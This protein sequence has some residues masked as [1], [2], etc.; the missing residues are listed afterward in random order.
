MKKIVCKNSQGSQ[1]TFCYS[2]PFWLEEYTGIHELSGKISTVKSAFGTGAIYID[3]SINERNITISGKIRKEDI[4]EARKLLYKIFPLKEEGTLYYYEDSQQGKINY[5]V[6]SVE[7]V[8]TTLL[9]KFQISLLCPNPYFT[10][11][12]EISISLANWNKKFKFPLVI[13]K[14]TG[15]NFA[16]KNTTTMFNIE[17]DTNIESGMRITYKAKGKVVN[18]TLIN[19]ITQEKLVIDITLETDE[20]VIV[21]TYRNNKNIILISN[22]QQ[23]NI[24]NYLQYESKFLQIHRGSNTFKYTAE[25]NEDNLEISINYYINYEAM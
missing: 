9:Y 1:A 10:D 7:I 22:G 13:P 25:E 5:Y 14:D 20:E 17:N 16:T 21:T 12:N 8:K 18:P 19:I 6:E 11:F 23:K 24:N 15:I 4:I 3:S 2:F